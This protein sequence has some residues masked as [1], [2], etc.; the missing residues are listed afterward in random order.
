MWVWKLLRLGLQVYSYPGVKHTSCT[1]CQS[2]VGMNGRMRLCISWESGSLCRE[3]ESK[4]SLR[5]FSFT[6]CHYLCWICDGLRFRKNN[7]AH[8]WALWCVY[9]S[10]WCRPETRRCLAS[11]SVILGSTVP[12][13]PSHA[14][15]SIAFCQNPFWLDSLFVE[16]ITFLSFSPC[17][18]PSLWSLESPEH[19]THA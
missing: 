2:S 5:D 6:L 16:S 9:F 11:S 10:N 14:D 15:H 19:I 12:G 4:A 8:C 1:E 17:I 13:I 18:S 7:F 3:E